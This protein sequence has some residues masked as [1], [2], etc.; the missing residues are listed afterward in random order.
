MLDQSEIIEVYN[1]DSKIKTNDFWHII[2]KA[3]RSD[4]SYSLHHNNKTYN[5]W[6]LFF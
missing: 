1:D 2:E 3:I 6:A 5:S 4:I